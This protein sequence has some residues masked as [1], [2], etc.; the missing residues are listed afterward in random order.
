M[1]TVSLDTLRTRI[2]QRSDNEHTGSS[3]VTDTELTQLIN[4]SYQELYGHLV[5]AG[6]HMNESVGTITADGSGT[7][8]MPTDYYSILGVFRIEG[9]NKYRLARHSVRHRVGTGQT[10]TATSYRIVGTDVELSPRPLSGDYEIIYVPVPGELEDDDDLMDGV[11]GW[12]EYVVIDVAIKVLQK[13]ESDVTTLLRER[14]RLLLRIQ[15][16]AAAEEMTESWTVAD[17][18]R[19]CAYDP[20]GRTELGYRGP[21]SGPLRGW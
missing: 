3:F 2:R 8:Q 9:G 11:L 7:Y 15:E 10:G 20:D 21:I 18:R 17:V 14:E 1:A 5:R 6:L 16:E 13:E 19:Q 12:E 4:T